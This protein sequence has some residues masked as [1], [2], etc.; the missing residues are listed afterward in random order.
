MIY[1]NE[2]ETEP[3]DREEYFWKMLFSMDSGMQQPVKGK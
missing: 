2:T 1:K 3:Q